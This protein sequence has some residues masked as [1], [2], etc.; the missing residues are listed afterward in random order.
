[1]LA[2]ACELIFPAS[3]HKIGRSIA[4]SRMSHRFASALILLAESLRA[5][6]EDPDPVLARFGLDAR[7][8][9]PTGL[10]ARDLE[11]RI[12]EALAD[13]LRDPLSGLKAGSSLGIGT[14]GPFTLLLLTAENA[15]ADARAAVEF[16]SLTFLFGRL[17]FEPGRASS[18]LLL[19]PARLAGKAFRFRTDLEVAGTR[20]LMRDLY[21][22]AQVEVVPLRIVMPYARPADAE[23]YERTLGCPVEWDGREA[24]FEFANEILHRRLAT[25]DAH[26]HEILRV[27]CRRMAIELER[28]GRG[29]AAQVRSHLA[30]CTGAFPTAAEAAALLG[31]S[32][33]SLRRALSAEQESYRGLLDAVRLEKAMELLRD[34]RVPI[35]HVAQKLGYSEPAAFIHAF[36]RWTGSS[37]AAFRRSAP[38]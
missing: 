13:S 32:E 22:A 25:A 38:R 9:D 17:A 27:Q 21:A 30:A 10:L 16:E 7:R 31:L 4:W 6:G 1:M 19:R 23:V 15:L 14:Y 24:R 18:A 3:A 33:R 11:I 8:L 20:K 29:I 5:L 35:E 36:R 12:A 26:A 34:S 2:A 28:D 37:P